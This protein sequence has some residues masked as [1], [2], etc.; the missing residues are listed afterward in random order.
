MIF[1]ANIF[2][3]KIEP[4]VNRR[5]LSYV[6]RGQL[7]QCESCDRCASYRTSGNGTSTGRTEVLICRHLFD[8]INHLVLFSVMWTKQKPVA[9][10]LYCTDSNTVCTSLL[11]TANV[12][13]AMKKAK[14]IHFAFAKKCI[15][16]SDLYLNLA[17][18]LFKFMWN[19]ITYAYNFTRQERALR[20]R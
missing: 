11:S 1:G 19:V 17:C 13:Y 16:C 4:R 14:K 5:L 10:R 8:R 2:L 7:W 12:Q 3:C 18:K 15:F 6:C 9:R 20:S